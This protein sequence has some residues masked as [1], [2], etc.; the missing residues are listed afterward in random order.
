MAQVNI[1]FG[2]FFY[3]TLC[4]SFNSIA[5]DSKYLG[6]LF[7][8]FYIA[9]LHSRTDHTRYQTVIF[10]VFIDMLMQKDFSNNTIT[11]LLNGC[12]TGHGVF[13]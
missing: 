3:N 6:N 4:S 11:F 12:L 9:I 5:R 13:F 10:S 1:F 8:Y 7:I 2:F